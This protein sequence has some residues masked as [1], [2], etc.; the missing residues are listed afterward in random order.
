M[1]S[2]NNEDC[3]LINRFSLPEKILMRLAFYG[4]IIIGAY[5]IFSASILWGAIYT[6]FVIFGAM[7]VA[8]HLFCPHCPYPFKYET[9]LFFPAGKIK[10]FGSFRSEPMNMMEKVGAFAW[11]AGLIVIPQYLLFQ[12]YI[13]LIIFW[14]LALPL[15]AR[16]RIYICKRCRHF[17][18]PLN[19]VDKNLSK[20]FGEEYLKFK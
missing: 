2:K 4:F 5:A 7:L 3:T 16:F 10:L 9:C 11:F 12:N 20:E 17:F 6:A 15:L 18:C 8:W 13:L 14:V 1:H 19:A